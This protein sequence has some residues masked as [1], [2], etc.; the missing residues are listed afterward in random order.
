MLKSK[1]SLWHSI[2]DETNFYLYLP[3]TFPYIP[4]ILSYTFLP[5]VF[6]TLLNY[7][8]SIK[9]AE[10]ELVS[11]NDNLLLVQSLI[12]NFDWVPVQMTI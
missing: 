4:S 3:K 8:R 1:N 6:Y 2:G 10:E 9:H 12:G 7:L 11:R 5:F